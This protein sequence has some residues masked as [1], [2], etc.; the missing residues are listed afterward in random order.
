MIR[1]S[2]SSEDLRDK[3]FRKAKVTC[4]DD[5]KANMFNKQKEDEWSRNF[6]SPEYRTYEKYL[7][8]KA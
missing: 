1:S 2:Q 4:L 8:R 7:E 6:M 3:H 5:K